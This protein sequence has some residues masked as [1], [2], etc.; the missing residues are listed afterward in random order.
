[1]C[2]GL[3]QIQVPK[4]LVNVERERTIAIDKIDPRFE[5]TVRSAE[6]ALAHEHFDRQSYAAWHELREEID[7]DER[8]DL[9]KHD[10]E[11]K[12]AALP[13]SPEVETQQLRHAIEE[14]SHLAFVAQLAD[15]D[16]IRAAVEGSSSLRVLRLA[17]AKLAVL[18]R[19][20]GTTPGMP[21]P[22]ADLGLA[23][24]IRA[25]QIAKQQRESSPEARRQALIDRA[26]TR[27]RQLDQQFQEVR[28]HVEGRAFTQPIIT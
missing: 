2:D 1:M 5:A 21:S 18:V 26:A 16:M 27:R 24:K 6:E 10:A 22:A 13:G 15:L 3:E 4:S 19:E 25:D 9:A 28:R 7:R 14:N 12:A 8:S 23:L 11:V 20:S 17:E